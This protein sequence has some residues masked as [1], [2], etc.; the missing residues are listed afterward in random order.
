MRNWSA[1]A[2]PTSWTN[3]GAPPFVA[4]R[5][6]L[7]ALHAAFTDVEAGAGRTVFLSG[8]PGTG[9]SR[10]LSTIGSALHTLG[11]AVFYGDCIQE[12]GRPLEP[13]D[14]AL[15]PL[16]AALEDARQEDNDAPGVGPDAAL[17]VVRDT[18]AAHEGAAAPVIGQ[19]RMFDAVVELLTAASET[20]PIVLALD[21]V[22][23]AGED[24]VRLLSR[25]VVSTADSRI[26]V[27]AALRPDPP[28]R[29]EPL[30]TVIQKLAHLPAV[31]Q[32]P[33][34]PFTAADLTE[35]LELGGVPS[36]DASMSALALAEVTGGNP[37]LVRTTWREV[38]EAL[39]APD[40][41]VSM[42]ESVFELLRPR[43]AMLSDAELAVLRV[44]ALLGHEVDLLEL[45]AT[46]GTSQ[47]DTLAA[48]D[49]SVRAGLLEPPVKPTDPYAFPHAI[50]RQS[51]LE[52]LPPS[53][54][55][56]LHARIAQTLEERFPAAT[57][58]VQRLA[59]HYLSARALGY[60]DRAVEYLVRSA[61]SAAQRLAHEEAGSLYERA[62]D[63]AALAE[64][65]DLLLR[66]SARSWSY[67]S[68]FARARAQYERMMETSDPRNRL[69][70]AIGYEDSTWRPGLDG[71][72][73]REL[74]T[75]ALEGLP[76]DDR[77]PLVIEGLASL[78]RAISFTGDLSGGAATG[79]RAIALARE[80]GDEQTLAATLR[81]RI[82]HSVRPE[83]IRDR[84][85]QADELRPLTVGMHDDW[86]G[87]SGIV[88]SFG[89]YLIG[90]AAGMERA[91]RVLVESAQRWGSY[92]KYWAECARFGRAFADG[93]LVDASARLRQIG[94]I[95][96]GF[97]SDYT[98]GAGA[99]QGYMMRRETGKL[100]AV[101]SMIRGDEL[102]KTAWA[103]GLLALY[104]ELGMQ[105]PC[106]RTLHWLL[107][108]DSAS[109]H[110]SSD[111]PGRLAFMCEAALALG[112]A[113]A[114]ATLRPLLQDYSGY[115]LVSGFFVAQ[116]GPADR[117]LGELDTLCGT[118]DP[119]ED[120]ARAIRLGEQ[121]EAP[122]HL[123]YT[124]ASAA[125]YLRRA[126]DVAAAQ[127]SAERARAIAEPLRLVRV[128][129]LLPEASDEP[130]IGGLTSRETEV[131]RLIAEGL[132]NREI[133]SELV[134][135]EHT[136]ANH[137]RSILMKVGV[138]NRTRAARFAREQGLA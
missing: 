83:G 21:D 79:D 136:A 98:T 111:W 104:T 102:P 42:P 97:R 60:G 87:A 121:L 54:S 117:Y 9:K 24:A 5:E 1:P 26:L 51:V 135:S 118:G 70:A 65:R 110:V 100:G 73:S 50:A 93:R 53:E 90:D 80:L 55:M 116:F 89:S 22:H 137:V 92:W 7:R 20:R 71:R 44:G 125:A 113:D 39:T 81:A 132:S 69:R 25:I 133:A 2:L 28:D 103:P 56:R 3:T 76:D 23:W 40:R 108:H 66:R 72:R 6:E 58:R 124:S 95:E 123:A 36:E 48:V 18:F 37:Y 130:S 31:E 27:L 99:L 114:A 85:A 16:L 12:L 94:I 88:A 82:W 64:D 129:R 47:E 33:L 32:M 35:Y 41:R 126:G 106:R 96:Q 134:I 107:E 52:G 46:S 122:L 10:L 86:A 109:A 34:A 120:F 63:L 91:E 138:P 45:I 119:A 84:L 30:T 19:D 68:D 11:A 112:D 101:A 4:R 43:I 13:F 75:S 74:L 29:S 8:D 38:V 14:Q 128:L 15:A 17:A 67:A 61:E 78:G 57:R 77:D 59:Y 49:A 105:E 115:N 131:L 62:A 127:E